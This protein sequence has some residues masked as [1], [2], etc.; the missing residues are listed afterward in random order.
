MFNLR[1]KSY[2]FANIL[3]YLYNYK[4]VSTITFKDSSLSNNNTPLMPLIDAH[5]RGFFF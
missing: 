5:L 1:I 4:L 3:R 2:T